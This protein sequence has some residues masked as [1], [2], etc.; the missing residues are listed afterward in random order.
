[1]GRRWNA[2]RRGIYPRTSGEELVDRRIRG[3]SPFFGSAAGARPIL[4]DDRSKGDRMTGLLKFAIDAQMVPAKGAGSE[5]SDAE[6][7]LLDLVC[8]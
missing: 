1:M 3:D 2:D 8:E 4:V 5:N 6:P 7:G